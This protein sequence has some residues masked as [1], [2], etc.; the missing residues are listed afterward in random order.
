[1]TIRSSNSSGI[2]F[3][4]VG[5]NCCLIASEHWNKRLFHLRGDGTVCFWVLQYDFKGSIIRQKL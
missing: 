5:S 3:Q 1:M 4:H 2:V